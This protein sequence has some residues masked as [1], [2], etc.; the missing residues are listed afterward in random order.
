MDTTLSDSFLNTRPFWQC[1]ATSILASCFLYSLASKSIKCRR[2]SMSGT[3]ATGNHHSRSKMSTH[4]RSRGWKNT[5]WTFRSQEWKCM[6][7]KCPSNSV[8][9]QLTRST[10]PCIPPGSLEYQLNLA[11]V[12]VG[13]YVMIPY[14]MWVPW[15][16]GWLQTAISGYFCSDNNLPS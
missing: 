15:Q 2:Y 4:F 11:G 12:K 9:I 14:G 10:Q 8:C 16:C 6:G 1:S 3:S 7:V 13:M 5:A